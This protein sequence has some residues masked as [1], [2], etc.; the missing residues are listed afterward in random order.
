MLP[1][2]FDHISTSSNLSSTVLSKLDHCLQSMNVSP[3]YER[4]TCSVNHQRSH[5]YTRH[6][7][8][9]TLVLFNCK[10]WRWLCSHKIS[11]LCSGKTTWR[12][13]NSSLNFGANFGYCRNTWWRQSLK[14][15]LWQVLNSC[16]CKIE[17]RFRRGKLDAFVAVKLNISLFFFFPFFFFSTAKLKFQRYGK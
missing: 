2:V 12:F 6:F 10:D 5:C 9:T 16:R 14:S 17:R 13:C 11:Q 7:A 3:G 4:R 15:A 8:A 1:T